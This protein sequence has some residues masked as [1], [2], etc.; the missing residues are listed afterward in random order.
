MNNSKLLL[1]ALMFLIIGTEAKAQMSAYDYNSPIGWGTVDGTITGG[2]EENV[3]KVTTMSELKTA[4]IGTYT[5]TIYLEGEISI[6]GV[7]S[8]DNVQNKTIYGLP[9][10]A[11]VNETHS[12]NVANSGILSLKNSKNI[13]I[14]NVTFKGAG[15][16]DIDGYDNLNL[17]NSTYIWI[18]HCDFQDGVDGN[19][20]CNKG[21]DHICV[22]WCR[23]RYLK[24]PWPGGSGGSDDHR[25][26]NL[27]GGSDSETASEGKLRT[28][29]Y[30]CWWDEG[31]R[32]R[33]P[34]IRFG[35]VH[36]LNCLYSS[37]VT[38]YCVGTGYKCNAYVDRCVFDN[39]NNPWKNYATSGN[40][41]DYN[42]TMTGNL[43]AEDEQSRS[44]STDYFMP[45]DYYQLE[46]YSSSLVE[47]EVKAHAGATL[48]VEY[49]QGVTTAIGNIDA[50]NA[51]TLS[52]TYYSPSGTKLP[53]PQKGLNIVVRKMSDG[54]VKT[55]KMMTNKP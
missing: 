11:L 36:L 31:C 41:T 16:Y 50:S 12:T 38:N 44:G 5:K 51:E 28:T 4:L 19:F 45:S 49:G 9:G 15:A 33:M 55:S 18:D 25:F 7:I 14:R 34:R 3:T 37:S 52:V 46:G 47:E 54:T 6:T 48:S 10:S 22:T 26:S 32:E 40:Y 13:I 23:F 20:D 29:F 8:M 35:Q 1:C 53:Q 42:I 30:S 21:S 39:V 27:W 17:E 43:G 2:N 24:A